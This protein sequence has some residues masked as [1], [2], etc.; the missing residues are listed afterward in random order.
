LA[1]LGEGMMN[2][3]KKI[4]IAVDGSEMSENVFN[5]GM[6]LA[7]LLNAKTCVTAV[8]DTTTTYNFP[9]SMEETGT[10]FVGTEME[11]MKAQEKMLRDFIKRMLKEHYEPEIEIR[12]GIP[13]KEIYA[14]AEEWE[15]DLLIIGSHG[16]GGWIS[17]L[18]FGST[19]EKLLK[20]SKCDVMIVKSRK[21]KSVDETHSSSVQGGSKS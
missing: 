11:L 14:C 3:Y 9:T 1:L 17:D 18:L 2:L 16:K 21:A 10:I 12:Y 15:A 6:E 4:L 13:H 5:K 20:M 8:V 7:K 19:A